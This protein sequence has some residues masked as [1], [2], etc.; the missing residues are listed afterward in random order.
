MLCL[1]YCAPLIALLVEHDRK[2]WVP[3]FGKDH[4]QI[5]AREGW[6]FVQ[7]SSAPDDS[8]RTKNSTGNVMLKGLLRIIVLL[9][10]LDIT[11]AWAQKDIR[12][13][14]P[15]VGTSGHK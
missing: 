2:K 4:A 11:S 7:K 10:A 8:P 13:G 12:W 14:T 9:C 1:R 15:P 3:I 5:E 6:R